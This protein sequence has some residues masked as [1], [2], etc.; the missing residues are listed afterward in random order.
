MRHHPLDDVLERDYAEHA[1]V[2][3]HARR[4]VAY[5]LGEPLGLRRDHTHVRLGRCAERRASAVEP[6]V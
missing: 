1:H 6:S 2:L 5:P 4:L 3:R